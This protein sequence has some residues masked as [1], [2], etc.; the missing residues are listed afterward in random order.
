MTNCD[1]CGKEFRRAVSEIKRN[2]K[3]N[4]KNFCSRTCTGKS[5]IKNLRNNND[6]ILYHNRYKGDRFTG[7]RSLLR[8]STKRKCESTVTLEYLKEVWENQ[9]HRCIY[10]RIELTLPH[11][12]GKND[13]IITASLDRIDSTKGYIEG[14]I[15]FVSMAINYMKSTMSH[16]KTIELIEIIKGS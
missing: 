8:S 7:L 15:Q 3:R 1:Y 5:N 16:E 13:P 11:Y 2:K 6:K 10:S 12:K 14:N 9:N 4:S